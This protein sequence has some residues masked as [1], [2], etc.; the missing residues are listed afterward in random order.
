MKRILIYSAGVALAGAAIAQSYYEDGYAPQSSQGGYPPCSA[1][2]TDR[3]IQL[4]EPGVATPANLALNERLGDGTQMAEASYPEEAEVAYSEYDNQAVGGPYEPVEDY[5]E[6][7][8]AYS[9]EYA[10]VW[11]EESTGYYPPCSLSPADDRCIQTYEG[12]YY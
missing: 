12:G 4:Y 10:G 8:A 2:V 7:A 5:P 6:E 11:P 9:E 1:T 3:C